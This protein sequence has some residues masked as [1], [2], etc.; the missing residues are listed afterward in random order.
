AAEAGFAAVEREARHAGIHQ[1]RAA[2]HR[3]FRRTEAEDFANALDG[4]TVLERR[5]DA[6][7]AMDQRA[8]LEVA[9]DAARHHLVIGAVLIEEAAAMDAAARRL[10]ERDREGE[11]LVDH[12]G[13]P[14]VEQAA[15]RAAREFDRLLV[16][17]AFAWRCPWPRTPRF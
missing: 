8:V 11:V 16:A 7:A 4:V 13:D 14:H 15:G 6:V 17:A 5:G 9:V 2:R 1:G 12:R 3:D 10:R